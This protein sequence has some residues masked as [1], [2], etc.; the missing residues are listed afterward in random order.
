VVVLQTPLHV[1][2][3]GLCAVAGF[4]PHLLDELHLRIDGQGQGEV[5]VL[6]EDVV[7][8]ICL[9]GYHIGGY[10]V[11]HYLLERGVINTV[12]ELIGYF[13]EHFARLKYLD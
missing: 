4:G 7:Q 9:G 6:P 5:V 13:S 1:E 11:I 12:L 2:L 8:L 3:D 10:D